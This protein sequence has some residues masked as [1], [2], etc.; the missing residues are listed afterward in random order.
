MA[1]G[2][3]RAGQVVL[4]TGGTRGLG[5]EISERFLGDG[6]DV[7]VCGRKEPDASPSAGGRDA[8][9]LAAD[10]RDA[11]QVE[12]LVA[13]IVER[14]GHLDVVVNNAGGSPPGRIADVSPRFLASII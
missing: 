4:V 3:D 6:A 5:R 14:F 7:V 9:F 8:V 10:V 2:I 13:G 1:A 11:E 12:A